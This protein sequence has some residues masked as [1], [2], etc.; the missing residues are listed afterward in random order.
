MKVCPNCRNQITEDAVFCPVC[1]TAID[2]LPRISAQQTTQHTY[3]NPTVHNTQSTAVY[4]DPFDHTKDF[5]PRDISEN[6]VAAML[7]YL[8]GPVG[9]LLALLSSGSSKYAGFHA[10]QAMKLTV[11]EILG[12]VLL[13]VVSFVLWNI[14]LR[15]LM[16]FVATVSMMGLTVLHLLCFVQ[17]CK[18]K[19]KEVYLVC[20]LSF[21]K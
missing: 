15:I 11:A 5:D 4:I 21:L 20:N 2:A 3:D 14:R 12:A 6:K 16:S 1:G 7:A 10:K 9:I 13:A 19:A 8:L 18:G 17:V